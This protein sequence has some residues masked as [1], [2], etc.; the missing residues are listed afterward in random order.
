MNVAFAQGRGGDFHEGRMLV[1]DELESSKEITRLFKNE[2]YRLVEFEDDDDRKDEDTDEA[3]LFVN[4]NGNRV[5]EAHFVVV[6]ENSVVV[7]SVLG[8]IKVKNK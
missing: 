1:I 6:N 5:S 2:K 8:D 4:G 7:V 3:F